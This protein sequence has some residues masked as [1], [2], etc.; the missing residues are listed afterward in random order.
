[1]TEYETTIEEIKNEAVNYEGSKKDKIIKAK[2]ILVKNNHPLDAISS[3]ISEDLKGYID[4]SYIRRLLGDE[5]KEKAKQREQQLMHNDGSIVTT[6]VS[7]S[8]GVTTGDNHGDD[9]STEVSDMPEENKYYKGAKIASKSMTKQIAKEKE[10]E[11]NVADLPSS[12][13]STQQV[14]FSI[15]LDEEL[16]EQIKILTEQNGVK[17]VY[18]RVDARTQQALT[19]QAVP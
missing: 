4:S 3:K 8:A 5:F 15:E 7:D 14:E 13:F 10:L 11:E 9:D 1:M 2:D 6:E 12:G 19:V 16:L 17:K 18:I